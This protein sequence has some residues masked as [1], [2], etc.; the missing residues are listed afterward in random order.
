MTT[1]EAQKFFNDRAISHRRDDLMTDYYL[2]ED[3]FMVFNEIQI[4]HDYSMG[5]AIRT[6]QD[7]RKMRH[8]LQATHDSFKAA[9]IEVLVFIEGAEWNMHG[10]SI[11]KLRIFLSLLKETK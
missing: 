3:D 6:I 7:E 11:T 9:A 8:E 4:K 10:E 1:E 5:I 2:T